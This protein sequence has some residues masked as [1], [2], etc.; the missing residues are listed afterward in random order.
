MSLRGLLG[1]TI[2]IGL[3]AA[4]AHAGA[5]A[6]RVE[7]TTFETE[8]PRLIAAIDRL[9]DERE[10]LRREIER[11]SPVLQMLSEKLG[12]DLVPEDGPWAHLDDEALLARLA[13]SEAELA[14]LARQG[15]RLRSHVCSLRR[16]QSIRT[17][18]RPPPRVWQRTVELLDRN[19]DVARV[20]VSVSRGGMPAELTPPDGRKVPIGAFGVF[21]QVAAEGR[22][23]TRSVTLLGVEEL[24][25]DVTLGTCSVR[26]AEN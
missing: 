25:G 14:G 22:R 1:A 26:E 21:G 2:A 8:D 17:E 6:A 12:A 23:S 16:G 11:R 18:L 15:T 4:A 13:S 10:E 19:P 9:N 7:V 20:R 5:G 24:R 3:T